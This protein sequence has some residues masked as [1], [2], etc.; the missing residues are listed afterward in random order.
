MSDDINYPTGF[1]LKDI[2]SWGNS[3]MVYLDESSQTVVKSP[4]GDE[5]KENIAIEQ[6]IYQR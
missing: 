5:N 1:N 2:V 3:G 4:Y 6:R